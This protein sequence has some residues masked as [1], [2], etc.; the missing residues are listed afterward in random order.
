MG[1]PYIKTSRGNEGFRL[2]KREKFHTYY[3]PFRKAVDIMRQEKLLSRHSLPNGLTLEFW[4]LS[5]PTAG[6]R[7]QV[8]VEARLV[9]PVVLENLPPELQDKLDEVISSLGSPVIFAKQEVRNFVAA[10]EVPNVVK[11]IEAEMFTSIQRY[12]GH[13]EFA[14]R[15]IRKKY[16]E[17]HERQSWL[18][19]LPETEES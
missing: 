3:T 9:I 6:D 13:P 5:T 4:D 7:W 18:E 17:F 16:K 14:S 10:G 19:L 1:S 15:F 11:N 8:V 2:K 12:L